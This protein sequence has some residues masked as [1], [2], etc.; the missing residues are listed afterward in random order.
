MILT[1]LNMVLDHLA[2]SLED[3]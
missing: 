2:G 3:K 1:N